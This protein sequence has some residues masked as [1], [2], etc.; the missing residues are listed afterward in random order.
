[1]LLV[2]LCL[3]ILNGVFVAAEFSFV[4]ARRTK[5][6]LLAEKGSRRAQMALFGVRNLD[7]YLSVCQLGITL[8]SL[9]LGWIGEPAVAALLRPLLTLA[10]ADSPALVSS[11]SIALGFTLITFTHVVFGE[12]VPKSVSIQKAEAAALFLAAPMRVFYVLCFPLVTV[13]NGLSSFFVHLA[14]LSSASG[15]EPSHSPEELRMLIMDSSR[16]GQIEASEGRMLGNIFSFYKKMAKDIMVHRMDVRALDVGLGIDG[17]VA[18]ARE[19]GHTRFP[20][21]EGSRDNII[22]F[23]HAKDLLRLLGSASLRDILREPFYA[24]ETAHLDRLLELMQ[25]KRQQFCVVVDE[26]GLWQGVITMED[27]VEAIVGDIQDEFDNEEPDFTPQ[28]DGSALVS[29]ELSLDDLAAL[30]P[31]ACRGTDTNMYK[32]L[33]AHIIDELGRIPVP[34]DSIALCGLSVTVAAMDRNRIRKVR[35]KKIEEPE[36]SGPDDEEV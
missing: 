1:M 8:A 9:A 16:E 25:A 20:V 19:S 29:A 4:K 30:M 28:P 6:E 2:A 5:L 17:A 27:I 21:Y 7:A 22:G 11:L 24:Y 35:V 13:M 23:I 32:I 12:L 15:Q 34:G 18:L 33:A 3:V 14:G 10:G 26:Y 31:V 36:I